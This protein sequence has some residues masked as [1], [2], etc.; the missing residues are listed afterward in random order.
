MPPTPR[1]ERRRRSTY[2]CRAA[3]RYLAR[4]PQ[5]ADVVWS[6]AGVRPLYDDGSADP[7]RSRAT[8]CSGRRR[9]GRRAGALRIR[10]QDHD[11]PQA[12]RARAGEAGALLP[13]P[14][15][16][17]GPARAPLPGSDF[18]DREAAQSEFFQPLSAA[19]AATSCRR[20]FGATAR[21]RP[22]CS[23]TVDLGEDYGA[24][25]TERELRYLTQHEWAQDRRRRAVA[26]HQM[27]AC[28]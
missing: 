16:R 20:C 26:A 14:E 8:T 4:P 19:A 24:G 27:R 22:K 13:R 12:R 18:S 6:Y 11:L 15:A 1:R 28:T 25:L 21:A 10:R 5:P 23:A 17:R 7:S 3:N 2:L 9:G